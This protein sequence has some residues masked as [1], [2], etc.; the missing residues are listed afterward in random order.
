MDS[1]SNWLIPGLNLSSILL[2]HCVLGQDTLN[3]LPAGGG[4]NFV[5]GLPLYTND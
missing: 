2:S 4:T 1:S 3:A 5:A